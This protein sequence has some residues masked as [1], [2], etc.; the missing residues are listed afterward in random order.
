MMIPS[1]D[2]QDG[3]AVQLIGG[4]KKAI[5]AGDPWPIAERFARVGEFALIDL[6]DLIKSL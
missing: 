3:K 1:I 4:E 2:L 6:D 5:D